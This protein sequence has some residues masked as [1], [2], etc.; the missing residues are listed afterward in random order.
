[1]SEAAFQ[2]P[3]DLLLPPGT[4]RQDVAYRTGGPRMRSGVR[5]VGF[6]LKPGQASGYRDRVLDDFVLVYVLRGAGVFTDD[7]GQNV[8]VEAG[9]AIQMLPG[10]K[11]SV[12]QDPDG[13]WAEAYLL[14]D[15]TFARELVRVGAIDAARL[16]LRPGIDVSIIERFN[17]LLHD[18]KFGTDESMPQVLARAHETV[19]ALHT[20]D[21]RSRVP[22]PH[23]AVVEA[24]CQ[25][26]THDIDLRATLD[27]EL[28]ALLEQ[29]GLSYERFRKVFRAKTGLSPGDYRIRRRIDRARALIAQE[30]LSN[31]QVAYALGYEDPFTFSKQFKKVVGVSPEV[32]RTMV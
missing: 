29:H 32:F 2:F 13:R 21:R 22:E 11:H 12:V 18:L 14:V 3:V 20:A 30:R 1:M 19:V 6:V 10:H 25:M 28:S 26:L 24:A 5:S 9:C 27:V 23:A 17:D 4:L 31:K 8:R 15:G 16:V 7:R